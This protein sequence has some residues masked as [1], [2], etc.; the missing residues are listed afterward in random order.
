MCSKLF[1]RSV[2]IIS[3]VGCGLLLSRC[4]TVIPTDVAD[5]VTL[6]D[7]VTDLAIYEAND[8]TRGTLRESETTY[9]LTDPGAIADLI[10]GID[11]GEALDCADMETKNSAYLYVKFKD[12]KRKVYTL[13]L[14]NSHISLNNDRSTCFFVGPVARTIIESNSQSS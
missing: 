10:S 5:P 9:N 3:V 8:R 7:H 4:A 13:F 11:F 2:A 1:S 12:N 6:P 14:L